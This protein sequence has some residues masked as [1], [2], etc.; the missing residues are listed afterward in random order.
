[1][2]PKGVIQQKTQQKDFGAPKVWSTLPTNVLPKV[3]GEA[4]SFRSGEMLLVRRP[5][6]CVNPTLLRS[7]AVILLEMF[8]QRCK[9]TEGDTGRDPLAWRASGFDMG[10]SMNIYPLS[11]ITC[12]VCRKPLQ[13]TLQPFQNPPLS[14]RQGLDELQRSLPALTIVSAISVVTTMT[15]EAGPIPPLPA[16][17]LVWVRALQQSAVPGGCGR[18]QGSDFH[19]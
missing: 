18:V 5:G 2:Q 8:M 3:D 7:V 1:M 19:L 16:R 15:G 12:L 10:T 9:P 4:A 6:P 17:M 13:L 11:N 14:P